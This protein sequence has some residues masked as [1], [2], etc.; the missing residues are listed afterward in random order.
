MPL[1]TANT[2]ANA[3]K[4]VSD[5][6]GG[7]TVVEGSAAPAPGG[8]LKIVKINGKMPGEPGTRYEPTIRNKLIWGFAG[9]IVG[10]RRCC[11]RL[12]RLQLEAKAQ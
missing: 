1:K 10:R 4:M 6:P 2:P 8:V 5:S 9:V 3:T 12:C 7:I 11:W